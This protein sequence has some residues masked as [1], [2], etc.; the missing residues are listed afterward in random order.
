MAQCPRCQT[1]LL[2][3]TGL[4]LCPNCGH[5]SVLGVDGNIVTASAPAADHQTPSQPQEH[6]AALSNNNNL[7]DDEEP[8]IASLGLA[9]SEDQAFPSAF[10]M[11]E[12]QNLTPEIES[13]SDTVALSPENPNSINISEYANSEFSQGKNGA[14]VYNVSISDIDSKEI[15]EFLREAINDTRF[16]WD[17]QTIISQIKKGELLLKNLSPVKASIL[18][19]RIKRLPVKIRW[20]QYAITQADQSSTNS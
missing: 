18:I 20:E 9:H 17:T 1:E 7:P 8:A 4:V 6:S 15:R 16:N 5:P 2:Q 10:G 11:F 3:D 19:N 12:N 14:F 13:Q